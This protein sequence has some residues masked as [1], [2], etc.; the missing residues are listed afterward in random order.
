MAAV[1]AISMVFIIQ[2]RPGTNVSVSGGPTCAIEIGGECIPHTDFVTAFRL[3]APQVDPEVQNQLRIREMVVE[4]LIERWLLNVDAER[5]GLTTSSEEVSRQLAVNGVARFS[6]PAAQE[7][8][9]SFILMRYLGPQMVPSPY[10]PARR[11]PVMDPKTN[12]FDYKRYQRWVSRSSNKTEKDFKE[13]QRLELVAARMRELVRS[14]VRVSEA[15]ASAEYASANEKVV[16]DYLKLERSYY[17]DYVVD[18]SKEM[19]G[20]WREANASEIDEAWEAR[21]DTFMP[22]CRETRQIL[23]RVDETDPDP[24]GAKKK[25]QAKIDAARTRVEAGESFADVARDVSDDAA[26]A[27][28]GGSLGCFA[29]GKLARSSTT[30]AIDDAAQTLKPGALSETIESSHGLHLVTVDK[31]NEG[32]AAEKVGKTEVARDLYLRKE[33]ERMAAEAAKQLLAAVKDGKSLQQALDAHLDAVLPEAAKAVVAAGRAAPKGDDTNEDPKAGGAAAASYDAW[34]DPARPQVRKSDPFT[35]GAPPFSQVQNPTEATTMLFALED[36]GATPND[37]I[38]LYDGYAVAQLVERQPV[39]E[40]KWSE[41][42]VAFI[43]GLRRERQRDALVAYVNRLRKP[44]KDQ[45]A[46]KVKLSEE[47]EKTAPAPGA[48]PPPRPA[49][50]PAPPQ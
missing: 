41:E 18:T 20:K 16:V 1:V 9:F 10:G 49:P 2:F 50:P 46:I 33:S 30:K 22:S 25:A 32:E 27:V 21:K 23:A 44:Y 29:A 40:K 19:L 48:P 47:E 11:I 38:K 31:I 45:I 3:A 39:D 26:S 15:E 6:L 8:T 17:K 35:A 14:R 43:D 24:E 36:K 42:R 37:V 4:G 28:A 13:F 12:Q 5:L 34:T 7:E